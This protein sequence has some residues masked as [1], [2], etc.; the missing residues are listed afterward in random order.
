MF[1]QRALAILRSMLNEVCVRVAQEDVST[2]TRLASQIIEDATQD[3]ISVDNL[4]DADQREL[5]KTKYANPKRKGQ[6]EG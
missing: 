5:T 2:G 6:F 3:F 1:D 4:C